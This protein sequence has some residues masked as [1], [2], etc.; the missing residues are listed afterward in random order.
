MITGGVSLWSNFSAVSQ[1]VRGREKE[2]R[3][4]EN[5]GEGQKEESMKRLATCQDK[6]YI[7]VCESAH[8][9]A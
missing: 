4:N 2:E 6:E 3:S 7:S 8:F 9:F 5:V 1:K